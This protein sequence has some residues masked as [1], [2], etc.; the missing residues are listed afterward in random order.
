MLING[1]RAMALCQVRRVQR[2]LAPR[3][4]APERMFARVTRCVADNKVCGSGAL[5]L[6]TQDLA[7]PPPTFQAALGVPA[8]WT[9]SLCR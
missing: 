1:L 4:T 6:G 2:R 5:L 7:Q 8:P 3:R 9:L